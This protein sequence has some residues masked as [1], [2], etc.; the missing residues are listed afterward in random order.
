MLKIGLILSM[1]GGILFFVLSYFFS[2]FYSAWALGGKF[3]LGFLLYLLV[4]GGAIVGAILG[5]LGKRIGYY[6]CVLTGISFPL[7]GLY[8]SGPYFFSTFFEGFIDAFYLYFPWSLLFIGGITGF[9]E[10]RM[11]LRKNNFIS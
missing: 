10:W 4:F 2:G 11:E 8:L 6:L 5:F 9:I 7:L 3:R 1:I